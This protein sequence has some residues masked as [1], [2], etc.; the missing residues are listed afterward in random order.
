VFFGFASVLIFV[1]LRFLWVWGTG[2]GATVP[3][4][5]TGLGVLLATSTFVYKG[6]MLYNVLRQRYPAD[7]WIRLN[8]ITEM[9]RCSP[10][11]GGK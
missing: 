6:S 8:R 11:G 9:V 3:P 2:E 1:G 4:G 7:V 5:A 10:R